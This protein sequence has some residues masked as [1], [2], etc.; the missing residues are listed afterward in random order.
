MK[1]EFSNVFFY[2]VMNED[3]ISNMDGKMS[4]IWD[5]RP[6]AVCTTLELNAEA[7]RSF[8]RLQAV[9]SA[10]PAAPV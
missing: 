10:E 7:K 6:F 3:F 8:T 5:C 9:A 4:C 1:T 2:L